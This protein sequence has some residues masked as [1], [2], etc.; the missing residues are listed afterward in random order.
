LAKTTRSRS[1]LLSNIHPA[2]DPSHIAL[3]LLA[4]GEGTRMGRPKAWLELAGEPIVRFLLRQFA[5]GGPTLLV[6]APGRE[7]PPGAEAFDREAIDPVAG[8]GPMRGV[9]TALEHCRTPLLAVVTVDM[10]C[11]ARE[12]LLWLAASLESR[13][14]TLG[15]MPR[16]TAGGAGPGVE[17]FP[18]VL[19]ADAR[20][21]LQAHLDGGRDSVRSLASLKEFATVEVPA[22]WGDRVWTNLNRP[23]DLE[24]FASGLPFPRSLG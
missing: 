3:V 22:D 18:C 11:V 4:G 15:V 13:H 7:H 21:V 9:L 8:V 20:P 24:A 6:T 23:S 5:W 2:V 1:R 12:H 19:R 17:P 10:P 14:G 16:R